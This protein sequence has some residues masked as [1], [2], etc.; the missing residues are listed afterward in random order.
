MTGRFPKQSSRGNQYILV[1]Y[2]Y[3]SNCIL[4]IPIKNRKGLTLTK[5]WTA[6]YNDFKKAS[7][8]PST[9]VLNNKTSKDLI[10]AFEAER[11]AY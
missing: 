8:V 5:V 10:L 2:H 3:D 7:V 6:L 1:G 9:Y 4:G 11:I